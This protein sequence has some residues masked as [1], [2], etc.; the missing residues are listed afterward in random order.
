MKHFIV[1]FIGL[2]GFV[3]SGNGQSISKI[4]RIEN[5]IFP[6]YRYDKMIISS[7]AGLEYPIKQSLNSEAIAEY[8]KYQKNQ[9]AIKVYTLIPAGIS[10]ITF[11]TNNRLNRNQY[12]T[13]IGVSGVVTFYFNQ[14]SLHHLKLSIERYNAGISEEK[15]GLNNLGLNLKYNF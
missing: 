15:I 1:F 14:K 2:L 3:F 5:A 8:F 6:K 11:I 7:P 13:M 9:K 10:F 12:L 4:E